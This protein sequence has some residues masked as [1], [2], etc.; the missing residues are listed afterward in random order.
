MPHAT[1]ACQLTHANRGDSRGNSPLPDHLQEVDTTP[2]RHT[3]PRK[4]LI[5]V[6]WLIAQGFHPKANSTTLAVARDLAKRM[7]YS[8]GHARYC[9]EETAARLNI[10]KST[11][12]RHVAILRQL[13]SLA[14]V[15][16]G[17]KANMRSRMGLGGYAGTAT[18][19]AATIP[20]EYDAAMGR[21]VIGTGYTARVVI[22]MRGTQTTPQDPA[23]PVDN[24]PVDNPASGSCAPPSLTPATYTGQLQ[25]VGGIN[26][27]PRKSASRQ[28]ESAADQTAQTEQRSSK[29]GSTGRTPLQVA[30]DIL[31]ACR[32]RALV[33]WAQGE[34]LRR[35]A[36]VL[37]P[38]IDR[39]LDGDQIAG[40][41]G[42]MCLGW[43][44]Q[45][46]A[47]YIRT[48]LAAQA[49]RDAEM[50]ADE[51][52]RRSSTWQDR[53][54]LTQLLT[55]ATAEPEP[56]RTDD[57]RLRARLDWT[58]WPDVAAHYADAP[59]DALDLYGTRLC[60]YAI[61]QDARTQPTYA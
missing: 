28:T 11:V 20:A 21:T 30:H 46:P 27:T 59:D 41:L 44:P 16:H 55:A 61:N 45:Q 26:Y 32:V 2:S 5:S 39:G 15:E 38:L 51:G 40:E 3:G 13:G 56:E 9:M 34:G 4:W 22:D 50:A 7:D 42:G 25:M 10:D 14:W 36:Y 17:T 49:A 37:R 1:P 33:N 31:V 19:Y 12:K 58:I 6:E 53:M 47:N 57:D 60:V 43:K 18:I 29:K 8:T 54:S 24:S 23:E 35:L 52:R 48:A